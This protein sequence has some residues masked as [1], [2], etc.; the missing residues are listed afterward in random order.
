LDAFALDTAAVD[1]PL[2]AGT[3]RRVV[4]RRVA[5]DDSAQ[6]AIMLLWYA[7]KSPVAL[8]GVDGYEFGEVMRAFG[9]FCTLHGSRAAL[10]PADGHTQ[11]RVEVHKRVHGHWDSYLDGH[12]RRNGGGGPY[13]EVRVTH[14]RYPFAHIVCELNGRWVDLARYLRA[15][16]IMWKAPTPP[17]T[18]K[19]ED[20]ATPPPSTDRGETVA[21]TP[22]LTMKHE[23]DATPTL[24]LSMK[25][26][27]TAPPTLT[28]KREESE[29]GNGAT[30][31]PE[32]LRRRAVRETE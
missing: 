15:A 2:W 21:P 4:V 8:A 20:D 31:P 6:G 3:I 30:R 5:P 12:G 16:G 11:L 26:E 10:T 27:E 18:M 7:D 1:R 17:L 9:V 19:H 24:S 13:D 25:R 14:T 22:P 28:M 29:T 32:H 23:D